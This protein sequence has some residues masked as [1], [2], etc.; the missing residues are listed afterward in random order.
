MNSRLTLAHA[1][2]MILE[3]LRQPA[4][5]VSTLA[6]PALFYVIFALPESKSVESANYLMASF[7]GFAFFGVIFLQFGVGLA[8]ERTKSWYRFL[9]TLPIPPFALMGARFATA[10][11]YAGLAALVIFLIGSIFSLVSLSFECW[12]HF[13]AVLTV[14]GLAF[15]FMGLALGYWANEKTSLPI[16]NLIY[17]PLSFAG[18]LWK[19]PEILPENLKA[20]SAYLPTRYYG[21][22]LW[23]SVQNKPLPVESLW[24]LTLYTFI[25]AVIA[26]LG[27]RKDSDRKLV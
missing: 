14:G 8:Q 18:G 3:L 13:L 7:A 27:Y 22:L 12:C 23:A 6:F 19:P 26:Y 10:M 11:L 21:N 25:F 9:K 17:L 20:V 4:Y 15:C 2:W 16:G 5:L 1:K 24:G